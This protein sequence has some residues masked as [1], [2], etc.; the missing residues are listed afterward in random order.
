MAFL[1]SIWLYLRTTSGIFLY[2]ERIEL[3]ARDNEG[4][5]VFMFAC[6]NGHKDIVI[7][8]LAHSDRIDLNA[9]DNSGKTALM[10]A[11]QYGHQN[12]INLLDHT[13]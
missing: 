10:I 6:G 1:K 11:C 8:L 3:N 13:D 4:Q 5:T 7:M 12:I 2:S 9:T